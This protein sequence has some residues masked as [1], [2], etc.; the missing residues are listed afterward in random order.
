MAGMRDLIR[1]VALISLIGL[2]AALLLIAAGPPEI[3]APHLATGAFQ[4]IFRDGPVVPD[5]LEKIRARTWHPGCPVPPGDLRQLS[6]SYWNF[7]QK[8]MNGVLVVSKDVA[9]EVTQIFRD[10]FRH[11]F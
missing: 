4:P 1:F 2:A 8:P 6:L 10:L 9:R 3:V 7:E 5:L 11:G